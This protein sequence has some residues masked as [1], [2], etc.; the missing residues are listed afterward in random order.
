MNHLKLLTVVSSTFL[1]LASGV[2][3]AQLMNRAE[4]LPGVTSSG[5]PDEAA[6]A[7]I[8]KEGFAAVIDLRGVNEDRGM[9]E[10]KV[11]ESLGMRYVA[12]PVEGAGGVTYEKAKALDDIIAEIDGP[13]LVHCA[14]GNRVG[15]V[16]A[17]REHM[18]GMPA[19]QAFELGVAA[20]MSSASVKDTVKEQ[21]E[22]R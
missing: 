2:A 6:L 22:K 3:S 17:L 9:E 11:V 7:A 1:L 10:Q 19:D 5:Q 20:G 16:L 4:P 14:S 12:I 15:G 21:L 13:V 18:N 8:A